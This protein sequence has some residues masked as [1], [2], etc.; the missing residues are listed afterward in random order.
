MA[1]SFQFAPALVR[2]RPARSEDHAFLLQ[3]FSEAHQLPGVEPDSA[4]GRM[5]TQIQFRGRNMSYAERYPHADDSIV[6]DEDDRP[7]G[8]ILIDRGTA[9]SPPPGRI[10]PWRIVDIAILESHRG[11]GLAGSL[12]HELQ[13]L[14]AAT[15][16]GWN[17][18]SRQEIP[19]AGSMSARD[20]VPRMRI[21]YRSKWHGHSNA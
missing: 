15:G 6:L 13:R 9:D 2:L 4:M 11:R 14:A 18:K 10:P 17:Y 20:S 8:R 12:V 19:R 21:L 3:L 5:L 16:G 7:V 1:L